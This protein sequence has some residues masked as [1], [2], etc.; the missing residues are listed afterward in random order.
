MKKLLFV[1][2]A[3]LIVSGAFA[4][5]KTAYLGLYQRGGA[6][7]LKTTLLYNN[8]PVKLGRRNLAEVLNMLSDLG[9]EIDRMYH[10]K[11][12]CL[13]PVTRHKYHII[14]K[15]EYQAGENPFRGLSPAE[16]A[17]KMYSSSFLSQATTSIDNSALC[18]HT[19]LA[20]VHS[21]EKE[22]NIGR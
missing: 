18:Q 17:K 20:E 19:D 8:T 10:I 13:L 14:L 3:L 15:K 4:Q 7:H 12:F 11:R 22:V 1:L 21:P 6:Q 9:W 16:I 2:A 5:N